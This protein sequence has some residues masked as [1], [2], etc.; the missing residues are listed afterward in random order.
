MNFGI[1]CCASGFTFAFL[2]IIENY[3]IFWIFSFDPNLPPTRAKKRFFAIWA[4]QYQF[5][6]VRKGQ[7]TC[8]SELMPYFHNNEDPWKKIGTLSTE[9]GPA[10]TKIVKFWPKKAYLSMG[11]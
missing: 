7:M 5:R 4:M 11:T 8:A 3:F 2:D 6:H 1:S 10:G 9:I